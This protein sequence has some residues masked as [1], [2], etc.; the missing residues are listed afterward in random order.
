MV[1]TLINNTG[2]LHNSVTHRIKLNPFTLKECEDF[3]VDKGGLFERYQIVQLY[4]AMG[5]IPFYL[6]KVD[7]GMSAS[8]N[9]NKLFFDP[10]GLLHNEFNNLYKSLFNNAENHN[11]ISKQNKTRGSRDS[12][13][14]KNQKYP[15]V[16]G[17]ASPAYSIN[18]KKAVLSENIYPTV[19]KKEIV[20]IS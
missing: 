15:W 13:S 3:L 11:R 5:G 10:V 20:F 19:K 18:W 14:S 2:G 6:N 17:E 8:Q 1:N 7:V 16:R 9:I 12:N 4:M